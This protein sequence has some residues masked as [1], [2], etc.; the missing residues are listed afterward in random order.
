MHGLPS[1]AQVMQTVARGAREAGFRV[2]LKAAPVP[3][4][5]AV[6][7]QVL[8]AGLVDALVCNEFEAPILLGW[9][10]DS[11][12][13]RPRPCVTTQ[14]ATDAAKAL[15]ER[16]PALAVVVVQVFAGA[17]LRERAPGLRMGH[18]DHYAAAADARASP[19]PPPPQPQPP[20]QPPQ[21]PPLLLAQSPTPS[22]DDDSPSMYVLPALPDHDVDV[23]GAADAFVG[24]FVGAMCH[25]LSSPQAL[26]WAE[27]ASRLARTVHGAQAGMPPRD[28]LINWL[29][30][31]LVGATD[32][33]WAET[34]PEAQLGSA[35]AADAATAAAGATG[36][37]VDATGSDSEGGEEAGAP[38]LLRV[39]AR[40]EWDAATFVGQSELHLQILRGDAAMVFE[41]LRQREPRSPEVKPIASH[42]FRSASGGGGGAASLLSQ[43]NGLSLRSGAIRTQ[44]ADSNPTGRFEP[45]R[46]IRTQN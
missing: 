34:Y 24:G 14:D 44:Q 2:V 15:M 40:Q 30:D 25:G 7:T 1:G 12:P 3:Q 42:L 33:R 26:V 36:L 18:A 41:Q 11:H 10:R 46:P 37:A 39:D 22:Q 20:P 45:N 27:G 32:G 16:W 4:L 35:A 38:T 19:P 9:S 17:V 21:P 13:P 29:E 28:K 43:V 23:V 5:L 6:I 31:Q 8:D